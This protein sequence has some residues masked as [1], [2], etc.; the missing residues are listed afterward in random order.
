MI[1]R[2]FLT[3]F[4]DDLPASH[5][6]YADLFGYKTAFESDW[7]VHLCSPENELIELGILSR[8]SE[9]SPA[10]F[11][12]RTGGMLTI[13]VNDVDQTHERASQ[14]GATIVEAPKN[15]FYGQRRMLV[16]DPNGMLLDVSS[17]CEP[18]PAWLATLG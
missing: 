7:F 16:T 1:E 12:D 15:L 8:T 2:S 6:F 4:S 10:E 14:M 13:V 5:E 3:I 18:D 9:I 11:R 17:E